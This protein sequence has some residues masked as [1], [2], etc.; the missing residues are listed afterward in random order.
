MKPISQLIGFALLVFGDLSSKAADPLA[1]LHQAKTIYE[2][3]VEKIS[4]EYEAE[5]KP[6]NASY[7]KSLIRVLG[8]VK[9]EGK[10]LEALSRIKEEEKRFIEEQNLPSE[11]A[12]DL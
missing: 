8:K 3:N 1:A 4:V 6:L 9:N 10:D 12:P 7:Y 2:T 5:L 11:P